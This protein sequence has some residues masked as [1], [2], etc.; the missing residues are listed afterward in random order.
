MKGLVVT[1]DDFG[2]A[3]EVN[4]AVERA[5]RDGLLTA[6]SLMVTGP[7]ADDALSRARRMPRLR[8]GLHLVLVEGRSVLPA[9]SLPDLVEAN[10]YFRTDMARMGAALFFRRKVRE[11]LHREI[12][13]QFERF[14]ESGLELDHVNTHKHFHLH[15][16]I[17]DAIIAVGQNFGV[18]AVRVPLEPRRTLRAI[19]PG[20]AHLDLLRPIARAS[21]RKFRQ[22]GLLTADHVFGLAWS[23]Q[24]RAARVRGIIAN[25]PSGLSEI[26]LHPATEDVFVGST[27]GYAYRNE[28]NALLDEKAM[29]LA[30]NSDITFGGFGDFLPA[31]RIGANRSSH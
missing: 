5:H 14:A 3:V 25:L 21:L 24:M 1:A 18:R 6:A 9:A 22:A 10:G 12:A 16:T 28:L 27:P 11:Q 20:A 31:D 17:A 30:R 15:P 29:T 7:A 8:V 23:G 2:S 13:A 26:Y 4:A 19:E